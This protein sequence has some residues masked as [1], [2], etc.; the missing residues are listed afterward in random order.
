VSSDDFL[1]V[2]EDTDPG[3]SSED[4]DFQPARK[5]PV[6]TPEFV[7]AAKEIPLA[8]TNLEGSLTL[9]FG[10]FSLSE[11]ENE[12]PWVWDGFVAP[13]SLTLLSGWPKVGKTSLIFA[14]LAALERGETFMG[15]PTRSVGVWPRCGLEQSQSAP[16]GLSK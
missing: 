7:S 11:A 6:Q 13:G 14:L 15:L 1:R 5:R 12:P 2:L 9:S 16:N 4:L 3:P 10:P 8:E